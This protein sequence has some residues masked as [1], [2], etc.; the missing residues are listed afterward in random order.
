MSPRYPQI[1]PQRGTAT[2][3]RSGQKPGVLGVRHRVWKAH[4]RRER[5][6]HCP[7]CRH[8][9]TRVLDSRVSDDGGAIRRRRSCSSD[10]GG[11]GKRFSTVE[12]MQLVVLKRNGTTE[13]FTRDKAIAGV[14]KACKGRPVTEDDLDRPRAAGRG[15][16]A[17]RRLG[18]GARP[19]GRDDDPAA[20]AR[21]RRGRLPPVR[22]RLQVVRER[23]GLRG[24][25][26]D[27]AR[28]ARRT[29]SA[30]GLTPDRPAHT[31]GKRCASGAP[32][33]VRARQHHPERQ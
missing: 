9:D 25:D 13:P 15:H 30:H 27:T 18:R 11:C 5:H 8:T 14:R 32:N 4:G 23:R 6:M 33:E 28:R 26:R 12:Q 29:T 3:P 16:P 24:R 17:R 1:R 10:N 20:A 21:A 19:R 31:V 2:E 22:E 7:Y